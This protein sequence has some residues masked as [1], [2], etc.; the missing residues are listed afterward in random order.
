M[1]IRTERE[2]YPAVGNWLAKYL[3]DNH[4]QAEI[5]VF[6]A[7]RKSLARL[8]KEQNLHRNLPAEW[9][10][11]DVYVDI[12]GFI[13]TPRVTAIAFAECKNG[14]LTLI[15]LSQL[16]GYSRIV[17]PLH[18]FLI[19]PYP[20][21]DS[22]RSLLVTFP[23]LDVLEYYKRPGKLSRSLVVARWDESSGGI[24]NGAIICGDEKRLGKL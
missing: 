23:R 12:V 2:M 13:I 3:Q 16:L 17:L 11:W 19:S 5:K 20:A 10:S 14:P 7:S 8:I 1:V 21:S 22:L 6:D 15:N 4:R 24:D 18:S 9:V